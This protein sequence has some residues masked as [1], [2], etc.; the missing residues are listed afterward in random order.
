[1]WQVLQRGILWT[2]SSLKNKAQLRARERVHNKVFNTDSTVGWASCMKPNVHHTCLEQCAIK[3]VDVVAHLIK[4][5]GKRCG[6]DVFPGSYFA[7]LC[8]K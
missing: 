8:H 1:M 4:Q 5:R 3:E 6:Y 7:L 2:P